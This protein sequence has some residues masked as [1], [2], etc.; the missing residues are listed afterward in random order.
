MLEDD[1]ME[2]IDLKRVLDKNITE[3]V[4][5]LRKMHNNLVILACSYFRDPE[6]KEIRMRASKLLEEA[7]ELK[8]LI[9]KIKDD[10]RR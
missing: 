2:E 7:E 10:P 6:F 3:I 8:D 4:A 9:S 1:N 5:E